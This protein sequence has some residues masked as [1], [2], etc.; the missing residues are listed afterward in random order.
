MVFRTGILVPSASR[1]YFY[2]ILNFNISLI[3]YFFLIYLWYCKLFV[4]FLLLL[5]NSSL[6]WQ[7]SENTNLSRFLIHISLICTIIFINK[8]PL[9]KVNN[10]YFCFFIILTIKNIF[11]ENRSFILIRFLY[12]YIL[13]KVLWTINKIYLWNRKTFDFSKKKWREQLL[14]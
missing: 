7:I 3:F 9:Y 5:I 11:N 1:T 12:F 13:C 10:T 8:V 4:I 14:F 2:I 6:L